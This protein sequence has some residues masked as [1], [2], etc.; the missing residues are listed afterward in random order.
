MVVVSS[1]QTSSTPGLCSRILPPTLDSGRRK[2]QTEIRHATSSV[3][4]WV[5]PAGSHTILHYTMIYTTTLNHT[6][7]YY[8]Y[9]IILYYNIIYYI[10]LYS[11][12][13]RLRDLEE[14]G[15][16]KK[17]LQGW[18]FH[19]TL[20]ARSPSPGRVSW[21]S[22]QQSEILGRGGR[23]VACLLGASAGRDP[24]TDPRKPK[25]VNFTPN[26]P[27]SPGTLNHPPPPPRA[28]TL[29]PKP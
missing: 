4:D 5:T 13:G 17:C 10:K 19:L 22:C 24:Q 15:V 27:T 21:T 20:P 12:T 18:H 25:T 23:W 28:P 3:T 8:T 2:K 11:I 26:T 9:Y 7:L 16:I 29:N 6:I 1:C 14:L